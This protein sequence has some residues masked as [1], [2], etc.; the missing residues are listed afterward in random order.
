MTA[1]RQGVG[2]LW[3]SLAVAALALFAA[4]L[5]L[6]LGSALVAMVF[7]AFWVPVVLSVQG[8]RWGGIGRGV[9]VVVLLSVVLLLVGRQSDFQPGSFLANYSQAIEQQVASGVNPEANV[10]RLAQLFDWLERYFWGWISASFGLLW[11]SAL[12]LGRYWHSLLD[13]PGAFSRE[14]E[15]VRLGLVLPTV[16]IVA[17]AMGSYSASPLAWEIAALVSLGVAWQG[18]ACVQAAFKARK[19]NR[20]VRI[21]FYCLLVVFALQVVLA[22][23][24]IGLFDN[25]F[26][27]R[28]RL[29]ANDGSGS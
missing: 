26:N 22:L 23:A 24:L 3:R 21:G 11:M 16:A 7:I 27:F 13:N 6:G 29:T 19:A 1:L 8:V 15:D 17:V 4:G 18:L 20:L 2:D 9:E 12:L 14:F 10:A 5:A 28:K 25:L